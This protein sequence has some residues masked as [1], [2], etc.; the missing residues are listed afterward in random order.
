MSHQGCNISLFDYMQAWKH[1][2]HIE[3]CHFQTSKQAIHF[4]NPK[5]QGRRKATAEKSVKML[6][7]VHAVASERFAD[8][9]ADCGDKSKVEYRYNI[10]MDL[11]SE[12]GAVA[13]VGLVKSKLASVNENLEHEQNK[14]K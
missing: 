10:A 7:F 12:W 6:S 1:F 2:L 11:Y 4:P 5:C 14:M 3:Q 13:K 9:M 8:Y